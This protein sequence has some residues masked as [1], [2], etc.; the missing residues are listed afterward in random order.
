MRA[1]RGP[2]RGGR[3]LA[4]AICTAVLAMAVTACG[5]TA[6]ATAGPRPLASVRSFAAV[7][8]AAQDLGPVSPTTSLMVDLTLRQQGS[9]ASQHQAAA[10]YDPAS[11]SYG[12]Y[13]TSQQYDALFGLKPARIEAVRRSLA[14]DGI[15]LGWSDGSMG[16]TLTGVASAFDHAFGIKVDS[17]RDARGHQF[18]ASRTAPALPSNLVGIAWPLD[19]FTDWSPPLVKDAVHA[20]GVRPQDLE[21]AYDTSGLRNQGIDGSGETVVVYALGDDIEQSDLD[22]F[23]KEFGLPA[24]TPRII[25]PS[26]QEQGEAIMDVSAIHAIAPGAKIILYTK[27][28]NTNQDLVN[29]EQDMV[30]QNQGA[31]LSQSWGG[32]EQGMGS[33][34]AQFFQQLSQ[35]AD[36]LGESAF[37]AT[38]DNGGYDC[39]Q[40]GDYPTQSAVG[41]VLPATAPGFTAVGGTRLELSANGGYYDEQGWKGLADASGGGGGVSGYYAKPSWQIGQGVNNQYDTNNMREVPD[42]AALG[43]PTSGMSLV[44]Q[45]QQAE[46]GGTSLAT[47]V[48]AGFTALIDQYLQKNGQKPAGFINPA[49][50]AIAAGSP[51]YPAFHD[52]TEGGNDVYPA[53][54]GYDL[55]TGLGTPDVYNLARD[56][57]TY[58]QNGGHV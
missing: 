48:W 45:G 5:T 56:I 19:R 41:P 30:N 49:L 50:Y 31:I 52:V 23:N 58:E 46:I 38:G 14:A 54:T 51:P 21:A 24:I 28:V 39:L 10:I 11:P 44:V 22:A 42:V 17:F 53:T 40:P 8:K 3:A 36:S 25:G 35:K 13:L 12:H 9:S 47:P 15:S 7:L 43:D 1:Q 6:Q 26:S 18:W 16:I 34:L 20:G 57:L 2:A 29:I 55:S 4:R 37:F 32:C 27:P 33:Q